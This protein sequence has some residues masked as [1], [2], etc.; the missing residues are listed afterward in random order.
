MIDNVYERVRLFFAAEGQLR[1]VIKQD[2]AE[3][4]LRQQAW[5]GAKED[6]LLRL[7]EDIA[8]LILFFEERGVTRVEE[9][10]AAD[11]SQLFE[12][13]AVRRPGFIA[14][15]PRVIIYLEVLSR[16]FR[17]L[18]ERNCAVGAAQVELAK[19][20][21]TE[22]GVLRRIPG[23]AEEPFILGEGEEFA[24]ETV[25]TLM[26]DM[27][28]YF[29]QLRFEADFKRALIGYVGP[30]HAI[31]QEEAAAFW[32]GFWDYF[33]FDYHL[34]A[35]DRTPLQH[36]WEA[37]SACED[38]ARVA[39]L[40]QLSSA[41]FRVF[42][43]H[44]VVNHEW[45]E[46]KDLFDGE[47]FQLP[48]P[49]F[50]FKM[51]KKLLFYGHVSTQG[52]LMINYVVSVVVS[53]NFRRRIQQQL[54][55]QYERFRLQQPT[56]TVADFLSRHGAVVRHGIDIM[57]SSAKLHL[58]HRLPSVTTDRDIPLE[59]TGEADGVEELIA[60]LAPALGFSFF[61]GQLIR[62]CWR[63][64]RRGGKQRIRRRELW[65]FAVLKLFCEQNKLNLIPWEWVREEWHL[66]KA[67]VAKSQRQIERVLEVQSADPRYLN[68][69]GFLFALF[70]SE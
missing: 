35:D 18:E 31:P 12:W 8:W 26:A 23:H 16:F 68:E 28:A 70:I 9:A 69:L 46:C 42:Y 38:P 27:E 56:A 29:R 61:D 24:V 37:K 32:L 47:V 45:V 21:M 3:G 62:Q 60:Q 43:I 59:Q 20:V 11:Y 67:A 64:Y 25:D 13:L 36:Y 54:L 65:A 55:G 15:L 57:V 33:L 17:Y 41:R 19:E 49:D 30:M 44:R 34:I 66:E 48:F 7:W 10:S 14:D 22:G 58:D 51:L 1:L 6:E 2:W 63:D 39:L 53:G 50:D 52:K 40:E 4:F 5:R